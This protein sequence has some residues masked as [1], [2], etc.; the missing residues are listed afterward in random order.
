M[1]GDDLHYGA[2]TTG[3]EDLAVATRALTGRM[4]EASRIEAGLEILDVGCGTG[5]PALYL[6]SL[7]AQVTGIT[8]SAVGVA[9][10]RDR[11]ASTRMADRL[12][13][14][15]RDGMDNGF[16]DG[17]FDRVWA[18]ESS[19]LMPERERLVA[20]CARV[21]RPGGRLA[22]CDIVLRRELPLLEVRRLR[23]PLGL[24]RL[25]FGDA[26]ME[27]LDR[28]EQWAAASGLVVDRNVDLTASTRPTFARWRANAH[29][30]RNEVVAALGEED[31]RRFVEACDVLDG[32]WGDGTLGYGLLAAVKTEPVALDPTP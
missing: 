19:H 23:E 18:L 32:F 6:A 1:L 30:H 27:P 10:A 28:Y 21:L 12:R 11:V 24:L 5:T 26:R 9:E 16:P 15:L 22:L 4:V 20:E 31:W 3:D 14:E 8:T 7:G 29:R 13:F 17:S 25:V 2:F